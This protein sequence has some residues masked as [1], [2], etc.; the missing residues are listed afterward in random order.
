M[1][2]RLL[3]ADE[4]AYSNGEIGTIT[5]SQT[6]QFSQPTFE[7]PITQE[8]PL[9]IPPRIVKH[10]TTGDIP[11]EIVSSPPQFAE[12]EN[13]IIKGGFMPPIEFVT[14]PI[15]QTLLP[16]KE[17]TAPAAAPAKKVVA[18]DYKKWFKWAL[19][20]IIIIVLI[21]VFK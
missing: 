19:I 12:P 11:M 18:T 4:P 3:F 13:P 16:I 8:Q 6:P 5:A 17:P 9:N 1:I 20:L 10:I 15:L 2:N 7:Q 14:P 21:R